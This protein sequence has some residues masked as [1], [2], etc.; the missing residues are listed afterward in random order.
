MLCQRQDVF[1]PLT[2]WGQ[3]DDVKRQPV[4]QVGSEF[5]LLRQRRKVLVGGADYADIGG[6][7]VIAADPFQFTVFNDAQHFFLYPV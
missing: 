2:Q 3:G 1:Q 6:D 7:G 5:S 4:Q